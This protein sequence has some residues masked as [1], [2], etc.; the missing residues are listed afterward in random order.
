[1]N[2]RVFVG[3]ELTTL[4]SRAADADLI[5]IDHYRADRDYQ[6]GVCDIGCPWVLFDGGQ[7]DIVRSDWVVNAN[8]DANEEDYRD[9]FFGNRDRLLLGPA[10][11]VLRDEFR[12]LERRS[13]ENSLNHVLFCFGGGD[14]RGMVGKA[15]E[16]SLDE[17]DTWMASLVVGKNNPHRDAIAKKPEEFSG[18][19]RLR[20]LSASNEMA[21][22]MMS[23]DLGIL[24]GGTLVFEAASA[25]LPC[26]LVEMAEN[27]RNQIAAW[28]ALADYRPL[29]R[30]EDV[31]VDDLRQAI[32]GAGSRAWREDVSS[33]AREACDGCGADRIARLLDDARTG[34]HSLCS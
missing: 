19:G 21:A 17:A 29:G 11:S 5:V 31:S 32:H 3:E 2:E 23:A 6:Q 26:L 27:Q 20:L 15:L 24:S 13:I 12:D 1:M 8:P 7:R 30:C 28:S 9:K 25:G 14:D 4:S 18:N 10:Y 33:R 22:V 16:V 34:G